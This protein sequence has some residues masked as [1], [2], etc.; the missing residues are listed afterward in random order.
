MPNE[1]VALTLNYETWEQGFKAI[2][3]SMGMVEKNTHSLSGKIAAGFLKGS[4]VV[5]LFKKGV[6][7][8]RSVIARMPEIGSAFEIAKDIFFR[9]FLFPVRQAILPLLS[10]MLDWVREHRA[11]FVQWGQLVV[12]VF[13][14]AW[15]VASVFVKAVRDLVFTLFPRLRTVMGEGFMNTMNLVLFKISTVAI[16][17]G[18]ALR[19]LTE[20]YGPGLGQIVE[21]VLKIAGV[22]V[23]VAWAAL[24]GFIQGL[25]DM[26]PAIVDAWNGLADAFGSLGAALG[27][28]KDK[29]FL[30]IIKGVGENLGK[31]GGAAIAVGL[32]VVAA[33]VQFLAMAIAALTGNLDAL[34]AGAGNLE[35]IGHRILG[36]LGL[37]GVA[38]AINRAFEG[39]IYQGLKSIGLGGAAE[40]LRNMG[41]TPSI[42]GPGV[43]PAPK[44]YGP[45]QDA[46]ITP[47]GRVIRTDPQD[48]LIATKTPGGSRGP[49]TV[50]I[51]DIRLTVTEGNAR[52]AG[53]A[54]GAGVYRQ[55]KDD[56]L[57]DG[58]RSGL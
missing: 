39:G 35:D 25:R 24:T 17:L 50:T 28:F 52:R 49:V 19:N 41:L 56:L 22:V 5:G 45:F 20:K 7:G 21:A 6:E 37:E 30:A 14:T 57:T 8:V 55:L 15:T 29:G 48:Y 40:A 27:I 1:D 47:E 53:E 23:G 18:L 42:A 16:A 46:V 33:A 2:D 54:F 13:R 58:I 34:K 43:Y 51:G 38:P 9:N 44:M 26:G 11:A 3:K 12:G 31:I 4:I 36:A 32:N 10:R